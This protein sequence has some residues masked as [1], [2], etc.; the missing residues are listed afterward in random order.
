MT[1]IRTAMRIAATGIFASTV[2]SCA[3]DRLAS[4]A[5]P[6]VKG[7]A[8]DGEILRELK[9]EIASL[10]MTIAHEDS[11][12]GFDR[13]KSADY[14]GKQ[15][16]LLM[17]FL[18]DLERQAQNPSSRKRALLDETHAGVEAPTCMLNGTLDGC[19]LWATHWIA[20]TGTGHVSQLTSLAYASQSAA[21]TVIDNGGSPAMVA[22]GPPAW[23]AGFAQDFSYP[24]PNC[25]T[26]AHDV[27]STALHTVQLNVLDF[28]LA[29]GSKTSPGHV[30]CSFQGLIVTLS[31]ASIGRNG[32][33]TISFANLGDCLNPGVTSSNPNIATVQGYGGTQW[34]AADGGT[35]GQTTITAT[36]SGGRTGSATLTVQ[37][38]T[39]TVDRYDEDTSGG[40]GALECPDGETTYYHYEDYNDGT[41]W[42]YIGRLCMS[43]AYQEEPAPQ[44]AGFVGLQSSEELESASGPSSL[45]AEE[46][47]AGAGSVVGPGSR[48]TLVSATP[49]NGGSVQL[50]RRKSGSQTIIVGANA[51]ARELV[52]ALS[53]IGVIRAFH[54]DVIDDDADILPRGRLE[55]NA[56]VRDVL[57]A[58]QALLLKVRASREQNVSGFGRVPALTLDL[59]RRP[60]RGT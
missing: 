10:K 3:A 2:M 19:F 31:P 12:L 22:L 60:S 47:Y 44:A 17:A 21:V 50:Q 53:S 1:R 46:L 32:M 5:A 43:K 23:A 51:T 28:G 56:A 57:G 41:G 39:E 25:N 49:T 6:V 35:E 4:P 38:S 7:P 29:S 58:A 36:C 14:I 11:S 24:A 8:S 52:I 9:V 37:Y 26:A 40:G 59:G 55:D 33:S 16:P 15:R 54:G 42:H 20:I 30:S 34:T 48:V 45:A 13:E 27:V 18:A